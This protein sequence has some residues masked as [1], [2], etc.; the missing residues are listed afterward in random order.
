LPDSDT[1]IP[2]LG[3]AALSVTVPIDDVPPATVAGLTVTADSAAVCAAGFTPI[4][5]NRIESTSLA[6]SWTVVPALGKVV[7]VKVALVAPAGTVTLAGTL[8]APGWLLAS[9]T[10]VPPDG[11]AL[12]SVTVPS[13]ELPPATLVGLTLNAESVAGGGGV[14]DGFTV[15]SAKRVT[16]PPVTEIRTRVVAETAA[17]RIWMNPLVLPAGTVTLFERNGSTAELLL[18]TCRN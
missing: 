12:G 17:G 1:T 9:V 18:V 15:R 8:A 10:T 14:P 4:A 6:E 11:A 2:P 16:P 5:A 3:A 13:A 7:I